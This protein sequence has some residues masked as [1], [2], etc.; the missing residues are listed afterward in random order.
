MLPQLT[1]IVADMNVEIQEKINL[2]FGTMEIV[3]LE[4]CFFPAKYISVLEKLVVRS[5]NFPGY[6]QPSAFANVPN[7]F[8]SSGLKQVLNSFKLVWMF[9][10]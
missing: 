8:D 3:Y 2:V 5:C 7:C 4:S 1:M 6:L 10:V 9:F